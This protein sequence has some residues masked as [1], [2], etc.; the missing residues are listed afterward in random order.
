[1][2]S[3]HHGRTHGAK[4]YVNIV[5]GGTTVLPWNRGTFFYGT[6]TVEVTVLPCNAIPRIPRYYRT[7]LA[8]K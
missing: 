6:S 5:L 1:M 7:V 8:N 4:A 2:Y 3:E